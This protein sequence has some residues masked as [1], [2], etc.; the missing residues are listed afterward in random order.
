[1]SLPH[2][3]VSFFVVAAAVTVAFATVAVV[4]AIA[5]EAPQLSLPQLS[6]LGDHRPSAIV[7]GI[8]VVVVIVVI[9]VVHPPHTTDA[10]I[11]VDNVPC[12][13]CAAPGG[14]RPDPR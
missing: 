10:I 7:D 12:L 4:A 8:V 3:H 9:V 2:H 6:T 1:M 13:V 11:D 5:A 14:S